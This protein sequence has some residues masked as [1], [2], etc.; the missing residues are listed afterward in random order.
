VR[1]RRV[2]RA[3]VLSLYQQDALAPPLGY[4]RIAQSDPTGLLPVTVLTQTLLPGTYF[5]AVSGAG[6][7]YFSP[8]VADSGTAGPA[9]VG[10][11]A[12][13]RAAG[14]RGTG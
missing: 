2:H 11:P 3:G 4:Q 5:V 8:V 13:R 7:R 12:P 6:N 1:P 9:G 14:G 10:R